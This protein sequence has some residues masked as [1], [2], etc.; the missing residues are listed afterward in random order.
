MYTADNIFYLVNYL[1]N[2]FHMGLEKH[3]KFVSFDKRLIVILIYSLCLQ[4]FYHILPYNIVLFATWL[5]S[6]HIQY[7][8]YA[9]HIVLKCIKNLLKV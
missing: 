4:P 2:W 3:L 9:I 5:L 1:D 7:I 8:I 6:C